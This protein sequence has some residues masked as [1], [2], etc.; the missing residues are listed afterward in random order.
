MQLCKYSVGF[1]LSAAIGG[2]AHADLDAGLEVG[3]WFR[4]RIALLG[5]VDVVQV[6]VIEGTRLT[7]TAL[8]VGEG[9]ASPRVSAFDAMGQELTP[10]FIKSKKKGKGQK[11]VDVPIAESGVVELRIAAKGKGLGDYILRVREHLPEVIKGKLTPGVADVLEFPART[12]VEVTI[13]LKGKG[14]TIPSPA[15]YSPTG[16]AVDIDGFVSA[17]KGGKSLKIG[18]FPATSDGTHVLVIPS[19]LPGSALVVSAKVHLDDAAPPSK[20]VV[21]EAPGSAEIKGSVTLGDGFWLSQSEGWS[22]LGDQDE[23][24]GLSGAPTSNMSSD[25]VLIRLAAGADAEVVAAHLGLRVVANAGVWVQARPQHGGVLGIAKDSISR[26]RTRALVRAAALHPEVVAAEPNYLREPLHV[27]IDPMYAKQ[28]DLKKAGFEL[29]WDLQ[30]GDGARTMAVLDTGI[31]FDHPDVGPRAISGFDFVGDTWNAGDGNGYDSDPTDPFITVGTHG[32]HVAGTMAAVHANAIGVVGGTVSGSILPVRVLGVLGGTDFDIAQGI[33][34][35]ARLQ[36][37]SGYLPAA[38]A[39]VINMS[40][41]GPNY[42]A[43]LADAVSAALDAGVVV[44][45]AAGNANSDKSFYPAAYPGVIAVS[46]TDLV[47]K[48]AFYSSYGPHLKLAAPGGDPKKDKDGDGEKDGVF[49]TIMDPLSGPSWGIKSGTSMAAPHV[50]AAA[51]LLRS[52]DPTLSPAMVGAF[53]GAGAEDIGAPGFDVEFG[54]GRLDAGRSLEILRGEIKGPPDFFHDPAVPGFS[55]GIET[56]SM[57]ALNRGGGGA[58]TVTSAI[59]DAFWLTIGSSTGVTPCVFELTAS[60]AGLVAGVYKGTVTLQTS[61]GEV[62]VPVTLTVGD[63]GP[64]GVDLVHVVVIDEISGK[65]AA[66]SSLDED[67]AKGFS[68]KGLPEGT[69]RILAATDLDHDGLAGEDHDYTA[70][71]FTA[72]GEDQ[73][74]LDGAVMSGVHMT[75]V[76]GN[77]LQGGPVKI[78][79]P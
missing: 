78:A 18:P 5:D 56:L 23:D 28:W 43:I 14:G 46:A 47:D 31:R 30:P 79:E 73:A 68:L 67:Q 21:L 4:G 39:E 52:E 57:V 29:A 71:W 20:D 51:F 10:K 64:V 7:L 60:D 16:E 24:L 25:E 9:S 3:Q 1:V 15:L 58:I 12:G 62:L 75:A 72:S 45:A 48:R 36:N 40:L 74:L 13:A 50:S 33:L 59:T 61:V 37:A 44:V 54:H 53:L 66:V 6:P 27:P 69:Y 22:A 2:S 49:S 32:T 17:A 34:Y 41:G 65:V 35:A 8:P 76:S 55:P 42:S 19:G 26:A 63:Y 77:P 70:T 11:L 38:A